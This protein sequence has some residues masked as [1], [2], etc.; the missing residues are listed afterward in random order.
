[1]EAITLRRI[2]GLS[3]LSVFLPGTADAVV[4]DDAVSERQAAR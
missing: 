4:Y 3:N 1:M 2:R